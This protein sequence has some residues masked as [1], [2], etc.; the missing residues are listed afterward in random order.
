L[1]NIVENKEMY[2]DVSYKEIVSKC[3]HI[4]EIHHWELQHTLEGA[5]AKPINLDAENFVNGYAI[6]NC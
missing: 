1:N 6:A 4:A 3:G 2:D 5:T